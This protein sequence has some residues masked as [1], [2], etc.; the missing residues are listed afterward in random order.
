MRVLLIE[1]DADLADV[2]LLGLRNAAYA[3]DHAPTRA[4]AEELLMATSYDVACI[5]LGL[6][7]GDGLDLIASFGAGGPFERPKRII[8]ITARDAVAQRVAGLDAGADDYLVKPFAFDELLARLRAVNRRVDQIGTTLTVGDLALDT[9]ALTVTRA[10]RPIALTGRELA[11][12]R[13]LMANA[14]QV[15]SAE[16][17]IE[18]VWDASADPFSTSVR[19]IMSRLR[20]KLGQPAVI[21]TV[22]GAGYRL[23]ADPEP[24][25]EDDG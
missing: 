23:A 14:G 7:D 5:D 2:L 9:A 24:D 11:L 22:P 17:L 21:H 8:V 3:T 10:G 19:V 18:H 16:H 6:P 13:Y 15:L 4:A 25:Q 20:A 12:L 1:D